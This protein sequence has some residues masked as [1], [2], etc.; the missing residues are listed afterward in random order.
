MQRS[1][2]D[3]NRT[4]KGVFITFEGGDGTGKSTSIAFVAELFERLGCKTV[5]VREP[6]GT[7]IGESIRNIILD[8]KSEGMCD[9]TELLL[10]EAARAQLVQDVI[11]PAL[12]S[13]HVVLSDRFTDSTLAYQGAGRGIDRQVIKDL[14]DYATSGL[15]PDL[16]ILLTCSDRNDEQRR[17]VD[18]GTTDRLEN[19]GD[20]FRDRVLDEFESIAEEEP[21]RIVTVDTSAGYRDTAKALVNALYELI[22]EM[23]CPA[24]KDM[25]ESS[26]DEFTD[27]YIGD[28]Q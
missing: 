19:A 11:V 17:I 18:R 28:A 4:R 20:D 14:N 26:I 8:V 27:S 9:R 15:V 2:S 21:T 3:H 24:A 10:Y 7:P 16:T 25:I 22:P 23:Q 5:L 6:G 1:V 12:E 13:D